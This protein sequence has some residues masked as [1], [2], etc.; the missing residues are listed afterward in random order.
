[1]RGKIL[2]EGRNTDLEHNDEWTSSSNPTAEKLGKTIVY[3]I[4]F[5][6]SLVGNTL[7]GIIVYKKKKMRKPITNHINVNVAMCDMFFQIFGFP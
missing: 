1:M 5:V 2:R 4:I 6:V 3:C 7:I